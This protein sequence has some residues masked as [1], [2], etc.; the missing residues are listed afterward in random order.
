VWGDV[1]SVPLST[2]RASSSLIELLKETNEM[3]EVP[4][5]LQPKLAVGSSQP[6]PAPLCL[7]DLSG[8]GAKS[9]SGRDSSSKAGQ[10]E[11]R[12]RSN[13]SP[14]SIFIFILGST[15]TSI[16][17]PMIIRLSSL[18]RRFFIC[19]GLRQTFDCL[20]SLRMSPSSVSSNCLPCYRRGYGT[21]A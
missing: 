3:Q 8:M 15:Y 9:W 4:L 21:G 6:N 19:P 16:Y 2:D 13:P 7:S 12:W 11:P 1:F 18:N 10:S 20:A 5:S 14:N 17:A